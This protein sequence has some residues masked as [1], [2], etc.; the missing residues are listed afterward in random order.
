MDQTQQ[1][2][3]TAGAAA[4]EEVTAV[5]A[6]PATIESDAST[7]PSSEQDV[8]ID[9]GDSSEPAVESQG[10]S[11]PASV[12]EIINLPR[13]STPYALRGG[14]VTEVSPET[15]QAI[16]TFRDPGHPLTYARR[17]SSSGPDVVL[18]QSDPPRGMV[19]RIVQIARLLNILAETGHDV[20]SRGTTE[21]LPG[22]ND[23]DRSQAQTLF[24]SSLQNNDEV[25]QNDEEA[26]QARRELVAHIANS[27]RL[28]LIDI[29]M[30]LDALFSR[31]TAEVRQV[32]EVAEGSSV[33]KSGE[34]GETPKKKKKKSKKKSKKANKV[35]NLST[36]LQH[37]CEEEEAQG[38][39]S[40]SESLSS[41][42]GK[43]KAKEE[44][45]P[46][47]DDDLEI[48][49]ESP[50]TVVS[51]SHKSEKAMGAT[52]QRFQ[53]LHFIEDQHQA[54]ERDR[55]SN[56]SSKSSKKAK[57]RAKKAI[58]QG[59]EPHPQDD[60]NDDKDWERVSE[61]P[62]SEN[63]IKTTVQQTYDVHPAEEDHHEEGGK[64]SASVS[65]LPELGKVEILAKQEEQEEEEFEPAENQHLDE[66]E[67]ER[68]LTSS[69]KNPMAKK[70][71]GRAKRRGREPGITVGQ[72]LE[73]KQKKTPAIFS[74]AK[75][76]KGIANSNKSGDENKTAEDNHL[77]NVDDVVIKSFD[78]KLDDGK[79]MPKSSGKE[80]HITEYQPHKKEREG[81]LSSSFEPNFKNDDGKSEGP[82][83][84]TQAIQGQ[85]IKEGGEKAAAAAFELPKQSKKKNWGKKEKK[86][87]PRQE[88]HKDQP[89]E[90]HDG[91]A[92][93]PLAE[94]SK[95]MVSIFPNR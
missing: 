68:P 25:E 34:G 61:S 58:Q 95:I 64:A 74:K 66:I 73:P 70:R 3:V 35:I 30:L 41:G 37:E 11:G 1:D 6:P 16:Q 23:L 49:G 39:P 32:E 85:H 36:D 84:K 20:F 78:S 18:G 13:D 57:Q 56:S 17:E 45:H 22:D 53:D 40:P 21:E 14:E 44:H 79:Q 31:R 88:Q 71:K 5:A 69:S 9:N 8:M 91:K 83:K 87:R 90:E 29:E 82:D 15:F 63:E 24:I 42:K 26:S 10:L 55:A 67:R 47:Q 72:L 92:P 94:S 52:E 43:G 60:R 38:L 7:K 89:V 50:P 80:P 33:D 59:K 86:L 48:D 12:P 28:I 19:S 75:W 4:S 81:V 2:L 77:E 54:G 46:A 76:K 62:D 65:A 93:T 51:E 27:G